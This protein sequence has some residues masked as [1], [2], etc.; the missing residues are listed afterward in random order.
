M[1]FTIQA[2]NEAT[3]EVR[4]YQQS[5]VSLLDA[6]GKVCEELEANGFQIIVAYRAYASIHTT[7]LY[8]PKDYFWPDEDIH[9]DDFDVTGQGGDIL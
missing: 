5:G 9:F 8:A 1:I 3:Q 6:T 4:N 7:I 2:T